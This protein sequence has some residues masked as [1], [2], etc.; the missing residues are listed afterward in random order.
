MNTV[1]ENLPNMVF[2]KDTKDLKFVMFNKA[3][4][5][6]LGIPRTD[7]I[8]KNDYDFFPKTE[9][10]F[11]TSKDQK[12][13]KEGKLVDIPEE[14]IQ[15][16]HG[17][18]I[19]HTKKIP[20][21]DAS[22]TPRFLLGISEDI[23]EQKKQE[24]LRVYAKAL[25]ASNKDLQDFIFVASH[26]LQEPLRKI[27]AFGN[28]LNDEE[29]KTLSETGRDYLKRIRD[30]S[31][32]M[33]TLL[34]DLLDLTRISTRAKPFEKVDL[35]EIVKE[36]VSDLEIRLGETGGK[37]EAGPPAG[38]RRGSGPNASAFSKPDRQCLEIS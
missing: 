3:G 9:A 12:T 13:I 6:L 33:S 10:D 32:R 25:E 14:T 4:E 38:D 30:A 8:G 27:Q 35:N 5:A 31:M 7:L 22:G 26:D 34:S 1:L 37:I 18:R 15:T 11:F 24:N 21:Q 2:V 29:G 23:T 16:R 20:V 36:V 19:L 17:P 28:F